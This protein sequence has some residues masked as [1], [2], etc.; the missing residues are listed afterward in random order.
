MTE[1]AAILMAPFYSLLSEGSWRDERG[2]HIVDGGAPFYDAYETSDGRYI[3][4]AAIEPRFYAL[5]R[6]HLGL[7]DDPDFDS[8]M[9]RGA[10]PEQK[11]KVAA[12]VKTK[13]R[14]RMGAAYGRRGRLLRPSAQYDRSPHAPAVACTRI[15]PRS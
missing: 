14:G 7:S 3:S 10:W 2:V 13:T 11:K 5:L 8:Q 15:L 4:V 6:A 1:G 9:D 12:I